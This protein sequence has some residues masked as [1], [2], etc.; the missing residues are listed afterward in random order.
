MPNKNIT[1]EES[2][3]TKVLDYLTKHFGPDMKKFN[4]KKLNKSTPAT[5]KSNKTQFPEGIPREQHL[6]SNIPPKKAK[7]NKKPKAKPNESIILYKGGFTRKGP[8][9]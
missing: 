8:C 9:K 3:I 1:D 5:P 6:P 7:K 2:F 4:Q